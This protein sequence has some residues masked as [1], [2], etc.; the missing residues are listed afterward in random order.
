MDPEQLKKDC[1]LVLDV[2]KDYWKDLLNKS[3]PVLPDFQTITPGYLQDVLP[4]EAPEEG[5]NIA[6][7]LDDYKKYILPGVLHWQHPDF[8]GYFPTACSTPSILGDLLADSVGALSFSWL[9]CPSATELEVIVLNWLAKALGL[10]KKFVYHSGQN[11]TGCR[12]GG[13]IECSAS[14]ASLNIA[15]ALRNR[16]A[17]QNYQTTAVTEEDLQYGRGPG[18]IADRSV[19]YLSDQVNSSVLRA[20][21]LALLQPRVI[22]SKLIG[23]RLV[24]KVED[25]QDAIE[26]DREKGFIPLFCIAT[27]G[28]T[29]TCE[30]DD[31][32]EIGPLC[33][34][35]NIWLHVDAAYAGSALLC[36]EF[37]HLFR[38]LEV[39]HMVF[40]H[41]Y[42]YYHQATD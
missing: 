36:T 11:E 5:E 17:K 26:V 1:N 4:N 25:I 6:L 41:Y 29:N 35:E 39:S 38:G 37:R 24:M 32:E 28:T 13:I 2:I 42:L 21:E 31:L 22:K 10:P 16:A 23:H 33:Q 27:L 14:V 40:L 19:V 30:F 8:H 7:I 9:A 15:I 20:V 3:F 18:A 12:G 34:K